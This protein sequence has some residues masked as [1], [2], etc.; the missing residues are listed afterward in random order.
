MLCNLCST[1]KT[2]PRFQ[3]STKV[4]DPFSGVEVYV[5]SKWR[6]TA[7]VL[8]SIFALLPIITGTVLAHLGILA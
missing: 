1:D 6:R 5:V 3:S 4:Y 7:S 8:I 2:R